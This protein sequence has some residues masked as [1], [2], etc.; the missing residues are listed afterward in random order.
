MFNQFDKGVDKSINLNIEQAR[1]IDHTIFSNHTNKSAPEYSW[2]E[3]EFLNQCRKLNASAKLLIVAGPAYLTK[4]NSSTTS[5]KEEY[6]FID[7]MKELLNSVD[8]LKMAFI[9]DNSKHLMNTFDFLNTD[10][11]LHLDFSN[12]F[13]KVMEELISYGKNIFA[14][15]PRQMGNGWTN[16]MIYNLGIP[17]FLATPND[18]QAMLPESAFLNTTK[19]IKSKLL[20]VMSDN[21]KLLEHQKQM[22]QSKKNLIYK[23]IEHTSS[24]I[25]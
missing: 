25:E 15:F 5:F 12:N 18:S 19:E 4:L 17:I 14:T 24:L 11:S 9:G 6:D 13:K 8:G 3:R 10:N 20:Q 23:Q 7:L 22:M 1:M 16:A 21:N 2:K